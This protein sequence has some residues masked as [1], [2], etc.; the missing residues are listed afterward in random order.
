MEGR[1][2]VTIGDYRY[3][4][5]V[6]CHSSPSPS[7]YCVT[8]AHDV[9][10]GFRGSRIGL[11][12]VW[13][14]PPFFSREEQETQRLHAKRIMLSV[15]V[16]GAANLVTRMSACQLVVFGE[17][18]TNRTVLG[19]NSSSRTKMWIHNKTKGYVFVSRSS[20]HDRKEFSKAYGG[21]KIPAYLW[22]KDSICR[23]S[24]A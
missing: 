13:F 6:S 8:R 20:L 19:L 14:P 24:L 10:S 23:P 3:L 9:V 15:S 4:L 11:R 1:R 17:L 12:R 16:F 21:R 18:K 7:E 2:A 22:R 5:V